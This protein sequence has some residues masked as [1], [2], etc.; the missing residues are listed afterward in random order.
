MKYFFVALVSFFTFA[1][2]AYA[3]P[4][5]TYSPSHI[6]PTTDNTNDLG[7]VTN[8][9]RNLYVANCVGCGGSGNVATSSSETAGQLPYWTTTAGTPAKLGSVATTSL[10]LGLGL[11]HSA[12]LGSLVGGT[13]GSLTIATSSLYSG[14]Q[15]QVAYFSGTNTLVGTSSLF[16]ATTGNVGIGTVSPDSTTRLD[17]QQTGGAAGIARIM[18]TS[19]TA[20]N[21][22]ILRLTHHRTSSASNQAD[23][24]LGQIQVGGI[25]TSARNQNVIAFEADGEWGTAGDSTD[26]PM[27][28]IFYSTADGAAGPTERMRITG[29]GNVGIG[30]TTP[31]AELNIFAAATPELRVGW[32]TTSSFGQQTFVENATRIGMIQGIGSA[33]ATADRQ[34]DIELIADTGDISF[35]PGLSQAVTVKASGDVGIG[36]TT[37]LS[38]LTISGNNNGATTNNT[39]TF[40]DLDTGTQANQQI[41]RINFYS[42]DASTPGAS[43]KA[44]ILAAAEGVAPSA[45]LAFG[46]DVITGTPTEKMR[47]TS[48]GLVGIASTTPAFR[49]SLN[50][51]G[52]EFYVDSNGKIVGRDTTNNWAGRI[53]P[54]RSFVLSTATTTA[55]QGTTSPAYVPEAVMPFTGTLRQAR[56]SATTTQAYFGI[57]IFIGN[58]LVTPSYFIA[59]TTPGVMKFT[60]NNTFS[61]ST[62]IRM[63]VGTTT[64]SAQNLGVS[65]TFD[66]TES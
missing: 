7:S 48:A 65:C 24:V 40:E 43:A 52:S 42:A 45:Y 33:F 61:S 30:T 51:S 19:D 36:T 35:W 4:S 41:G 20:A 11:S 28:T 49:F 55:W 57:S 29:A 32:S 5:T 66:A 8:R 56:C 64:A 21:G 58:T 46:T 13:S 60:A 16:I 31:L 6:I 34:S 15:G 39:L 54:T 23:D 17:V 25:D 26:R 38:K 9:W 10:S 44:Y 3:I 53:S 2:I 62:P 14:T 47:I 22:A 63:Y 50:D 37:P 12:T 18:T 1:S 59:S 27:R